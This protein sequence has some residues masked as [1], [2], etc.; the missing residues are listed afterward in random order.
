MMKKWA[1]LLALA[2]LA[3]SPAQESAPIVIRAGRIYTGTGDVI[4]HG[5]IRIE[6]G[7]IAEVGPVMEIPPNAT[8]IDATS[9][10]I[11]PGLVGAQTSL[12]HAGRGG[13]ESIARGV[14]AIDGYDF[15]R[16]NWRQLSGGVTTVYVSPGSQRLLSG[17][18][19]ILKTG[20]KGPTERTLAPTH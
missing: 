5:L 2:I 11:I 8:V 9:Q 13:E 17:Q 1:S 18:G 7:K 15:Y 16:S 20:G 3:A 6:H 19:A 12:A 10:T 4:E 14:R